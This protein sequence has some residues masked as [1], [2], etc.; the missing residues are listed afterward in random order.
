MADTYF[1]SLAPAL[2]VAALFLVVVN[3]AAWWARVPA[4]Y[5]AAATAAVAVLSAVP[6]CSGLGATSLL[7]SLSPTFS[8]GTLAIVLHYIVKR[9]NGKGHGVLDGTGLALFSLWNVIV[10]IALYSGTLGLLPHDLYF[11]GYTFSWLFILTAT[12]TIIAVIT[13]SRLKWI[14]LAY[15]VAWSM[16]GM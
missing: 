12:L 13:G 14:F 16:R 11:V 5:R 6:F 7:L 3:R 10:C 4:P 1:N 2:M 8:I 15:V 9:L